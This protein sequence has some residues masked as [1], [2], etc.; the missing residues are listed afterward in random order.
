MGVKKVELRVWIGSLI[1]SAGFEI[2]L[3]SIYRVTKLD[4]RTGNGRQSRE[5]Y[6]YS[7]N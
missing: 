5:R 4:D 3:C 7:L 2:E 6:E 1:V